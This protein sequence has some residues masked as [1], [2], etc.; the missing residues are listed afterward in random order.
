[1]P[2]ATLTTKGQITLPKPIRDRLRLQTGDTVDFVVD[3]AG[4]I[5]VRAGH[6]DIQSL[7]GSLHQRGRRAVSVEAM[8]DAIRS[9]RRSPARP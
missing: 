4:E 2:T 8:D 6:V 5:R 7:R 1:M 9:A 3:D